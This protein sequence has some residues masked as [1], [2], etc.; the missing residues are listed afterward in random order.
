[1]D[2]DRIRQLLRREEGP[3]LDF[4]AALHLNTEGEK[5][6]LT[7]DVIAIANSRGGR[8][9]ILFGVEDKTKKLLG[10]DPGDFSEEQIQQIIYNRSDP[11]VPVTVDFQ[12]YQGVM[13][14]VLTIF[15]SPHR[16]H[17][18]LQN[19]AFYIR[20]GSTTDVARRSEIAGMLQESGLLTYETVPLPNAQME[21]LDQELMHSYFKTLQVGG[22]SPNRVLLQA[23]GFIAETDNGAAAPTIG[24]M[25]LFG[26]NPFIFLPHCH[27]KVTHGDGL[28]HITGNIFVMMQKTLSLIR[29]LLGEPDYPYAAVEDALGNALIHRDYLD[30][31]RGVHVNIRE[32]CIEII[33][34]GALVAGN[35]PVKYMGDRDPERRNP[36]LYERVLIMDQGKAFI[37]MGNGISRITDAFSK[38]DKVRFIN[39]GSRN[40]FK[41]I[42]P[43]YSAPKEHRAHPQKGDKPK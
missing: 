29:E 1:M 39:L 32:N 18:M 21:D 22:E 11:P 7:K 9:Y 2:A 5:K 25:L 30:T 27:V 33:N 13:L 3:K 38:K 41:V 35:K 28:Y 8:G 24:A 43:R 20:R 14:A 6:E 34:P 31:S 16:P 26:K 17:Q 42:L 4:K 12:E 19:G 10:I 36:W 15:K 40:L 23:L 37:N